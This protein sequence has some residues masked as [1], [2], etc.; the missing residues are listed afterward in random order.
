MAA[1]LL[2]LLF[3]AAGSGAAAQEKILSQSG[4][5]PSIT[6]SPAPA[7]VLDAPAAQAAQDAAPPPL[8]LAGM[9]AAEPENS[10]VSPELNCLA[11]AIYYEA[12]NEPLDGQLAVGR[13]IVARSKSGR[14][15]ASYCGVVLQPSQF[16]FVRGHAVP[17]V[18]ASSANWRKAVAIARIAHEGRWKSPAEGALFFHAARVHPRWA[19]AV[20]VA[21]IENHIF[22]R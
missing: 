9:V 8:T 2:M 5:E 12:R 7:L 22:Y 16:S 20:R 6:I 18:K 21:Q 3:S 1:T 13:V 15:P 4:I 10:E 14:F 19:K 11:G 17:P